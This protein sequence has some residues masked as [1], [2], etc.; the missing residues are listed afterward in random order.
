[1]RLLHAVQRCMTAEGWVALLEAAYEEGCTLGGDGKALLPLV[2]P[3]GTVSPPSL[4][5]LCDLVIRGEL[6]TGW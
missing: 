1:M 6:R 3:G 2:K 4:L 5:R